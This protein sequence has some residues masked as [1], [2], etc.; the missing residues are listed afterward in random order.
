ML[1]VTIL[2]EF[3]PVQI[4]KSIVSL[5]RRLR[6]VTDAPWRGFLAKSSLLLKIKPYTML[7]PIRLA[8]LYNL[9]QEIENNRIE[10]SIVECGVC[11]GGSA[12]LLGGV[13]KQWNREREIFLFDSFAGLPEPTEHDVTVEKKKGKKGDALGH[14]AIVR[15]CCFDV[16]GLLPQKTRI[17]KGWFAE[18]FPRVM[19]EMGPIAIL[20]LDCDWHE[21]VDYCLRAL[22]DKVSSGGVIVVD[23]YGFFLGAKKALDTFLRERGISPLLLHTKECAAYFFKP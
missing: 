20:H 4:R 9:M 1:R 17:I 14:E 13:S 19:P 23:D 6:L 2:K 21:S 8:N 3:L 11:N 18:S 15:E 10:G 22:Y 12:A 5:Y 16:V 7:S